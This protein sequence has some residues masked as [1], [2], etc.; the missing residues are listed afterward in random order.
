LKLHIENLGPIREASI[1]TKPFTIIIGKNNQG[2]SYCAELIFSLLQLR[3][4]FYFPG[5]SFDVKKDGTLVLGMIWRDMSR[6]TYDTKLSAWRQAR[7]TI[8]LTQSDLQYSNEELA[9]KIIDKAV[10]AF[11]PVL[12][13]YLPLL[14]EERFGMKL[15]SLVNMYSSSATITVD[16]SEYLQ[17]SFTIS[18]E[19]KINVKTSCSKEALPKLKQLMIPFIE[20]MKK[21]L[22][23]VFNLKIRESRR[24]TPLYLFDTIHELTMKL[25]GNSG[26][27]RDLI[28]SEVIYIP[29]GRAGLLE[30]YYSVASAYFSLAT[31]ALPR[32]V[33]MPA[34]PPTAS[35]FYNLFMEFTAKPGRMSDVASELAKDVLGGEIILEPDSRQPALKKIIYRPFVKGQKPEDIDI[36]HAGSMVKELAGLYLAI[37]EKMPPNTQLIVEEPEAHLHPSAQ[38]KLAR[39]LMKLASRD[40]RVTVTTHSDILLREIAH[41]IGRYKEAKARDILPSTG[42]SVILL[43]EGKKGSISEELMIPPTGI[44]EG[45]PTFDEVIMQLYEEEVDLESGSTKE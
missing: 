11:V 15:E 41:L 43:K 17:I 28:E 5:F 22:V 31:V 38:R 12:E 18:N 29:A 37:R 33:S 35:V 34:M 30:G 3:R 45:L 27:A 13:G 36:I 23:T 21:Q 6:A 1:E 25:V 26:S 4:I 10:S 8:S 44:L 42:V 19:G 2:K 39:V 20:K 32:G 40:V 16:F 24:L 14:L 7:A 9:E